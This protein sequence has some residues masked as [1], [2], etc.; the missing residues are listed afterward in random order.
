MLKVPK[1]ESLFRPQ[2]VNTHQVTLGDTLWR[3]YAASNVLLLGD[4]FTNIYSMQAMGWG[5]S[6]G[7]AE[8][9]SR[10]LGQDID[11]IARNS[12]GA[13]ATRELLQ[14]DLAHG[15]DRLAGK[16]VVVWEFAAREL[17]SGNWKLIPLQVRQPSK[18]EFYV[19]PSG[20]RVEVTATVLETSTVPQPGTVPYKDHIMALHLVDLNGLTNNRATD[21]LAYTWSMR[22]N[23]WTAAASLR[24]GEHIHVQLR[25]WNDVAAE[26]GKFNRSELDDPALQLEEPAWA[27]LLKE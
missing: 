1:T 4:S 14:Y 8:H 26:L 24:A 10:A 6:S 11:V 20:S 22:D 13:F 23:E 12:D 2:Q 9:L 27:D 25:A 7:F 3:G 18:S 16:K 21:V 5:E 17:S 19:P 15:R